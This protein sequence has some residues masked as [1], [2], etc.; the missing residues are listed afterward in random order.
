MIYVEV[1]FAKSDQQVVLEVELESG[2]TLEQAITAS[3][4]LQ[5]FPEI[6]LCKNKV[7]VFN[8]ICNLNRELK[9][10]DRV[11]IYRALINDPM[12]TRRLRAIRTK[13]GSEKI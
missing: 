12:E 8:R 3:G 2:A 11:E 7:G 4:I 9:A 6:N 13:N 1:A 10:G 5:R